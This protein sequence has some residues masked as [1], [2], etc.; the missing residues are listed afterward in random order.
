MVSVVKLKLPLVQQAKVTVVIMPL[1]LAKQ[2]V[3]RVVES[4]WLSEQ[5]TQA[6]VVTLS[7]LLVTLLMA[8]L[9]VSF[10]FKVATR[11]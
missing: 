4:N 1:I 11:L 8:T 6:L 7:Y 2:R 9:A 3:V 10:H 5:E